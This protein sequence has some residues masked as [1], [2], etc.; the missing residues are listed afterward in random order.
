MRRANRR[1][2]M[3]DDSGQAAKDLYPVCEPEVEPLF[4]RPDSLLVVIFVTDENDCSAP[5]DNRGDSTK[6]ICRYTIEDL[7]GDGIPD[8]YYDP[9]LCPSRNVA[10]CFQA[11]C[12]ALSAQDCFDQRCR[13]NFADYNNREG[14]F[15]G[16]YEDRDLTDVGDYFVR[17]G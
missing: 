2:V 5:I 8:G 7:D 4:L 11:E 10:E 3:S 12:G 15:A 14:L 17:Q 9:A 1:C 13:V 16:E 6:V